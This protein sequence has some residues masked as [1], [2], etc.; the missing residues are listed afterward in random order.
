MRSVLACSPP[1]SMITSQCSA[2][3]R[4]A[5]GGPGGAQSQ[6]EARERAQDHRQED[7]RTGQIFLV[8]QQIFLRVLS[9]LFLQRQSNK[10][11]PVSL[12]PRTL[13]EAPLRRMDRRALNALRKRRADKHMIAFLILLGVLGIAAGVAAIVV[14]V[15]YRWVVHMIGFIDLNFRFRC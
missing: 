4:P 1:V 10:I 13:E 15:Q 3:Q 8:R 9:K 6:Q 2:A 5:G 12:A 11:T 7:A 14:W